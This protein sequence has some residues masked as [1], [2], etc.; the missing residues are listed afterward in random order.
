MS[1]IETNDSDANSYDADEWGQYRSLSTLAV[2]AFVL[3]LCSA[4]MFAGPLLVVVPLAAVAAALLALKGISASEGGLSG[5]RLAW[6]GLAFAIVFGV[7][8]FARVQVRDQ[9]LQRQA[10]Q[11]G[12]QWLALAA[13]GR[14]EDMLQLM[15]RAAAEKLT[16]AVEP[17]QTMPFFGGILAS[18]LIRQDP[19]VVS[20]MELREQGENRLPILDASVEIASKP[21]QAVF[22]YAVNKADS[23]HQTCLMVL[24]RFQA[25]NSEAIWLVD[26]WK[27]E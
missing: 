12:Q 18:A 19:L 3:G 13:E 9:I 25:P 10:D 20:L 24:K 1:S 2:V 5:A 23:Q 4:A 17:G 15:T 14:A 26:S 8:S 16:P 7:A 22:R 27:L 21:P 11:V 6:W